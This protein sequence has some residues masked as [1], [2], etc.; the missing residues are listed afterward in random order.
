MNQNKITVEQLGQLK[1]QE[2]DLIHIIRTKYR[3]GNIEIIVRDGVP[4]DVLK[5]VERVRLGELSTNEVVEAQ[6]S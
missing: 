5:T 4:W 1:Q 2:I 3:F 6:N